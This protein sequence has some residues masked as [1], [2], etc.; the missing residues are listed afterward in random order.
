MGGRRKEV[1]KHWLT[2]CNGDYPLKQEG[3]QDAR[4]FIECYFLFEIQSDLIQDNLNKT[5]GFPA[6]HCCYDV[7]RKETR[8]LLHNGGDG[9]PGL[10]RGSHLHGSLAQGRLSGS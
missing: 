1:W 4:A 9:L 10:C 5:A 2:D 7:I 3:L 6:A 8:V